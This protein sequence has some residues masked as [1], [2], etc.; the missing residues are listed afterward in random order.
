LRVHELKQNARQYINGRWETSGTTG[1]SQ[2]PSD[3][4]EAVAEYARADRSQAELAIRAAAEALPQWSHSG[5]QRRADALDQIGSELLAR[6]DELGNLL[7]R[8]EGK[9]IPEAIG[10]V[11]RAGN[12]FKFFA[13][14]ALRIGGETMAS[15]RPGVQVDVTRE[16][17]GVVGRCVQPGDGQRPRGRPGLRR[18][19]AGRCAE[20]REQGRYAAEFYTTVKTGYTQA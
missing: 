5:P 11:G 7:A 10:E 8:E 19:P 15:V 14:D 20:L 12:I 6:K 4:C 2:N 9:T 1:I 17:V 16:P 13:G 18:Q 3:T